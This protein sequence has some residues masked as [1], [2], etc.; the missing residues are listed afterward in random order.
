MQGLFLIGGYYRKLQG[1][2]YGIVGDVK[3]GGLGEPPQ[4]GSTRRIVREAQH[5]LHMLSERQ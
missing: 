1:M 5:V 2:R 4:F 3:G